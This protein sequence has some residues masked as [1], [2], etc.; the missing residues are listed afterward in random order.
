MGKFGERFKRTASLDH[1]MLAIDR[2]EW[3]GESTRSKIRQNG[4]T[5]GSGLV[6]GSH[7]GDGFRCEDR[8][9]TSLAFHDVP[10]MESRNIDDSIHRSVES[11][12]FEKTFT[13]QH[14]QGVFGER[15]APGSVLF[16]QH[17]RRRSPVEDALSRFDPM[18]PTRSD[19]CRFPWHNPGFQ[20]PASRR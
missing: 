15:S 1:V 17:F 11:R 4:T 9:E 12:G 18:S 10:S 19:R 7:D 3:T 16:E 20:K 6:A 8:I 14:L 5:N 2:P 13:S